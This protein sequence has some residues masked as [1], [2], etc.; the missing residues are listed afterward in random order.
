[1]LLPATLTSRKGR[2]IFI[3]QIRKVGFPAPSARPTPQ[4]HFLIKGRMK[5]KAARAL[6]GGM[7]GATE[8]GRSL[9]EEVGPC[10]PV[11]L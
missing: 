6:G 3:V 10:V 4:H 11:P 2:I 1:M 5:G 9:E 8:C 7:M